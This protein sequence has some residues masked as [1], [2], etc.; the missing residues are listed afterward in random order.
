MTTIAYRDGVIASDTGMTVAGVKIGTVRKIARNQKG[1]LCGGAGSATFVSEFLHWFKNGERGAP[2]DAVSTDELLDR[3]V[4]ILYDDPKTII[5]H[6][7]GGVHTFTANYYALGTGKEVA[8]G[9]MWLGGTAG[10]AVQAGLVHDASTWGT[11]EVLE[12]NNGTDHRGRDRGTKRRQLG[13]KTAGRHI[14]G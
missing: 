2:P 12:A 9:V 4:I 13:D 5:I 6:E 7:P 11:V 8:L 10:Q 14:R 3:A 1:D